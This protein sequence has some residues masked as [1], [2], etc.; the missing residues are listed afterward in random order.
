MSDRFGTRA[1]VGAEAG[2][3]IVAAAA[4]VW[5]SWVPH[6]DRADPMAA[7]APNERIASALGVDRDAS[8]PGTVSMSAS[9]WPLGT[10]GTAEATVAVAVVVPPP[11]RPPLELLGI[12]TGDAGD[13]IGVVIHDARSDRTL[14]IDVGAER[15]GVRVRGVTRRRVEIDLDGVG[16]ELT[17]SGGAS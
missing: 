8:S 10:R 5:A 14:V 6:A 12:V 3:F 15:D 11:P 7:S 16:C 17:L 1:W 13:P 2:A 9:I 4:C